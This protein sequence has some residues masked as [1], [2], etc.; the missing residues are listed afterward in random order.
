[1][2]QHGGG[3]WRSL[4]EGRVVDHAV[5]RALLD[6]AGVFVGERDLVDGLE[7]GVALVVV[8][9]FVDFDRGLVRLAGVVGVEGSSRGGG[10]SLLLLGGLLLQ[11]DL[12]V[13]DG[14]GLLG[15]WRLARG[16]VVFKRM[17]REGSIVGKV[18]SVQRCRGHFDVVDGAELGV[19]RGGTTVRGGCQFEVIGYNFR[20][21][22]LPLG[23]SDGADRVLAKGKPDAVAV[24]L[25][26][27][28]K[29]S[30]A[31]VVGLLML[32]RM[33]LVQL[34]QVMWI[35]EFVRRSDVAIVVR[36][37]AVDGLSAVEVNVRV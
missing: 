36:T 28:G 5:H 10:G 33:L 23:G 12:I 35:A 37:A 29:G 9:G 24:A 34:C 3:G 4:V 20:Y 18:H 2:G 30:S 14:L 13:V 11:D 15:G 21:G 19:G 7:A 26:L 16:R 32:G 31:L 8:L 27:P 25:V 1:M 6:G 17:V 22:S